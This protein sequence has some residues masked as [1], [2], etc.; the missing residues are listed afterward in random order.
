MKGSDRMLIHLGKVYLGQ[1][2]R[3]DVTS[4]GGT[5]QVVLV[6]RA[7]NPRDAELDGWRD[8]ESER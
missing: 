1:T 2:D 8:N 6:D 3:L 4:T 5:T 7:D